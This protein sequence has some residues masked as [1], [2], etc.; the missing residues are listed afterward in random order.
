MEKNC[1]DPLYLV[2]LAGNSVPVDVELI[3]KE[4]GI[5]I[6]E[7]H[8]EDESIIGQITI[9]NGKSKIAINPDQN[10][11]ATRRRFTIAH[12]IAHHCLHADRE[13][14]DSAQTFDRKHSFWDPCESE[15]NSFASELLMPIDMIVDK[16]KPVIDSGNNTTEKFIDEMASIFCVSKKA[17]EYRLKNINLLP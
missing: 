17:M 1:K 12:E 7:K 11:Y 2:S 5:S 4:L 15:A 6:E 16:V 9:D 8:F 14:K 3:A 10:Y 13:F